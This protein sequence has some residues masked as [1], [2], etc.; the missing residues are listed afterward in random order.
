[1]E[2][3][4]EGSEGLRTHVLR[5]TGTL[6]PGVVPTRLARRHQHPAAFAACPWV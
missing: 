4:A 3:Q 2:K 5:A 1:M 6:V